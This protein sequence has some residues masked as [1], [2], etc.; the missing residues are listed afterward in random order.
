[1]NALWT[2]VECSGSETEKKK[3]E[4]GCAESAV[5]FC[6]CCL[7][8]HVMVGAKSVSKDKVHP[9]CARIKKKKL[10]FSVITLPAGRS[11]YCKG[12]CEV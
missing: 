3:K 1:M 11:K 8:L 10:F 5:N 12:P 7:F 4:S 2:V 9:D 6:G